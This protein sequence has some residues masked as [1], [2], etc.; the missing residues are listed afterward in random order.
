MNVN[1]IF[2]HGVDIAL[3]GL[4][5][6]KILPILQAAVADDTANSEWDMSEFVNFLLSAAP[7]YIIFIL[8]VVISIII[9]KISLNKREKKL[10]SL[11][12]ENRFDLENFNI[13]LKENKE[14]QENDST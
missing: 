13:E 3:K 12:Q 14:T 7:Y 8:L 10:S 2:F 4:P 9:L 1:E 6:T 5:T 11:S